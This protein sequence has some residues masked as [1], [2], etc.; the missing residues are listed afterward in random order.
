MIKIS[1]Q[2]S[3]SIELNKTV[4]DF[5]KFVACI[6]V[7][8]SHY[9][10]YVLVNDI[11]PRSSLI[12]HIYD[13]IS[14]VGGYLGVALFFFFSGYGLMKSSMSNPLSIIDFIKRRL[15]KVYFPAVLISLIW[16]IIAGFINLDLLCN[17]RYILGVFW[18]FN[19]EVMWFIRTIIMLYLFFIIYIEIIK[20]SD[21]I[22]CLFF[23]AL[24]AYII[25]RLLNIGSSIS[26][27]F[28]FIGIA[29]AKYPHYIKKI[30]SS[31]R[32]MILLIIIAGI[33]VYLFRNNNYLLHGWINY[34]CIG[35]FILL[36]SHFKITI[37][38]FPKLLGAI[39]F[40]IYLVHYKVHLLLLNYFDIDYLWMFIAGTFFAA[41]V[42]N[43]LRRFL[44]V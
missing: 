15:T 10:G 7:A 24:S 43:R 44:Y 13:V 29:L 14:A 11:V 31:I 5:C 26:I 38:S 25:I 18:W 41:L 8:L 35:I 36:I 23:V 19:D 42:F 6:M 39:S 3:D 16:L 9:S 22:F 27:P 20:K 34:F 37:A 40:D 28:F 2:S 1:K 21:T 30:F 12:S 33:T 4:T 32:C 17:Q